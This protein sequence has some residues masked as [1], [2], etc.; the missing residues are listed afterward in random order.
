MTRRYTRLP[1]MNTFASVTLKGLQTFQLQIEYGI[2]AVINPN[3]PN[4]IRMFS[5]HRPNIVGMLL[6]FR[7]LFAVIGDIEKMFYQVKLQPE[8]RSALPFAPTVAG[9]G[10]D[11]YLRMKTAT[12]VC[13]SK[14]LGRSHSSLN[15]SQARTTR[16]YPRYASCQ[17]H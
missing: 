14:I 11:V 9:F 4:K 3:K 10:A 12:G 15:Y 1:L 5:S 2:H 17:Y 16:Y 8:D 6:R 13:L 7:A